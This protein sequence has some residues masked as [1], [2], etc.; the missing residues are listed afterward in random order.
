MGTAF[1]LWPASDSVGDRASFWVADIDA[2]EMRQVHAVCAAVSQHASM[3]V[4]KDSLLD[5]AALEAAAKTFD[6]LIYPT[7]RQVLG[8][9]GLPQDGRIAILHTELSGATAYFARGNMQPTSTYRH[10]NERAMVV[11]NLAYVQPG[12]D[13]YLAVLAHELQ[14]LARYLSDPTEDAW[15]NEGMSQ[16]AEEVCGF[17][18]QERGASLLAHPDHP[19]LLWHADPTLTPRDYDAAYLFI[20]YLADQYGLPMVAQLAQ[21]TAR[22]TDSMDALFANRGGMD[23]VFADW[24]VT[25][26]LNDPTVSEGEFAYE[27]VTGRVA[28]T[29][30]GREPACVTDTV[31]NYGADYWQVGFSS[32]AKLRVQFKGDTTVSLGPGKERRGEHVWWSQR[33]DGIHTWLE[34]SI[35]LRNLVTATLAYKLWFDIESG[36]D[37]AYLRVSIDDG[38]TWDLLRAPTSSAYDPLGYALG[39]AY[40]GSSGCAPTEDGDC[41]PRW[42]SERLALDPYCGQK[43]HLRWDYVTDEAVTGAGMFVGETTLIGMTP[44]HVLLTETINPASDSVPAANARMAWETNGFVRTT[45]DVPQNWRL[46]VVEMGQDPRVHQIP[47]GPDGKATWSLMADATPNEEAERRVVIIVA[48]TNRLSDNRSTYRLSVEQL[49]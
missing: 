39:P 48:A 32:E 3:W 18:R 4:G 10:S 36:W 34:S 38:A 46:I 6:T 37:Y 16:L 23:G 44:D 22:V 11:V 28:P 9:T 20:R 43:V 29:P 17:E 40:T 41:Q 5:T 45:P 2:G 8:G 7:V 14:H 49:P 35:D 33:G 1:D 15:F 30:L 27:A 47:V 24:L 21:H 12:D 42:L 26:L 31:A 19:L 13:A 25:N